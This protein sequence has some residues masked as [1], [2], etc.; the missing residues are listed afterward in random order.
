MT[1][2]NLP[3][4]VLIN[5]SLLNVKMPPDKSADLVHRLRRFGEDGRARRVA[6]EHPLAHP[7]GNVDAVIFG[8]LGEACRVIAHQLVATYKDQ[9]RR[10][11]AQVAEER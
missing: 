9:H 8:F 6:V 2:I 3:T 10:Q 11:P 5:S 7:Q 4:F 1:G